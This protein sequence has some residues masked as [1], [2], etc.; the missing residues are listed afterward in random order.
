MEN[1]TFWDS[2]LLKIIQSTRCQDLRSQGR[3]RFPDFWTD[4]GDNG[5]HCFFINSRT[6]E[7][8]WLTR[9]WFFC[10]LRFIMTLKSFMD[11]SASSHEKI[12]AVFWFV[13]VF[14][15]LHILFLDLIEWKTH[16]FQG[17]KNELNGNQS[18]TREKTPQ[19]KNQNELGTSLKWATL[20]QR[21]HTWKA[22]AL[23]FD[24][25]VTWEP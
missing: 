20:S 3:F 5:M 1:N 18:S 17:Q 19:Y 11:S 10:F 12:F 25:L 9:F 15:C 21:D 8:W 14:L 23:K 16:Y 4:V 7:H 2:P 22:Q 6:S 24:L 13:T